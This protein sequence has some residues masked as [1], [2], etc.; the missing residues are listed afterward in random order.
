MTA[1]APAHA[2]GARGG[3]NGP[4]REAGRA[5]HTGG[6]ENTH[7]QTPTFQVLD[8]LHVNLQLLFEFLLILF[9]LFYQLFKVLKAEG[10]SV[11]TFLTLPWRA[12]GRILHCRVA[13]AATRGSGGSVTGHGTP[14]ASHFS[15]VWSQEA[16]SGSEFIL[17]I[18]TNWLWLW[19]P[20]NL[21]VI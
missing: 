10:H 4:R 13:E 2:P 19:C 17:T 12:K 1:P 14:H 5:R 21:T 20:L 9:Q 18:Q 16:G 11:R 8:F 6:S 15:L 3:G 7:P